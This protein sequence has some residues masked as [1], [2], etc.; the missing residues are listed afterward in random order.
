MR[1]FE[2]YRMC[3]CICV[4]VCV[5]VWCGVV[6]V[7]GLGG[8]GLTKGGTVKGDNQKAERR[9]T[10]SL[11]IKRV[12]MAESAKRQRDLQIAGVS[13]DAWKSMPT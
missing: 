11:D 9:Q 2:Q 8:G 12:K 5:C 7:C 4:C 6:Y 3:V 10:D 1:I 13:H